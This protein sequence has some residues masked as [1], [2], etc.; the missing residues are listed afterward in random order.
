VPGHTRIFVDVSIYDA[1]MI[2][3]D[4]RSPICFRLRTDSFVDDTFPIRDELRR[5]FN[6][7]PR[8]FPFGNKFLNL[9]VHLRR[10]DVTP[11][12]NEIR[13]TPDECIL[14]VVD[15]T[16]ALIPDRSLLSLHLVSE[17]AD[18]VLIAEYL[19]RGF[20]IH[21]GSPAP[22]AFTACATADILIGSKSAFAYY[23]GLINTGLKI[24]P[25]FW[26]HFP[27]AG[28]WP[29]ETLGIGAIRTRD[30]W[31]RSDILERREP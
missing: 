10:G 25:T 14:K 17:T 29:P 5:R 31:Y 2:N 15:Q 7:K 4:P 19:S 26:H 3:D 22:E 24:F 21:A 27:S 28:F 30:V 18:K 16:L 8:A 1:K 6:V 9:V 13:Y 23:A 11:T 12:T 20:T